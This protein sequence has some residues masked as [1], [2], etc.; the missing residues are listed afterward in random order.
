MAK[1][2]KTMTIRQAIELDRRS[3]EIFMSFGMH[4]IGC[5]AASGE[6]IE[7]A[8]GVHGIDADALMEKLN[9]LE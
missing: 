1:F 4:C 5:P 7:Q 8:A 9:E 6:T 3:V 2:E